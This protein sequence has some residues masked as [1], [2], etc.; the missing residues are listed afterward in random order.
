MKLSEYKKER[1]NTNNWQYKTLAINISEET[2]E[3]M[4]TIAKAS[5]EAEKK[6]SEHL[7]NTLLFWSLLFH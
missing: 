6:A 3:E 1:I 7:K 2:L 4:E 5:S